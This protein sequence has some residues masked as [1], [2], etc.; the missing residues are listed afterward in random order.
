[1]FSDI[2]FQKCTVYM[3]NLRAAQKHV[4]EGL[5]GLIGQMGH[6]VG[7]CLPMV[8]KS[9]AL[10]SL[11]ASFPL[12]RPTGTATRYPPSSPLPL[13]AEFLV[14]RDD[15][16]LFID[17]LG[18]AATTSGLTLLLLQIEEL[19]ALN[20]T[21]F[22]DEE[23][24]QIPR[25]MEEI[26]RS[27]AVLGE[28][29]KPVATEASNTVF[30]VLKEIPPL[31]ASISEACRKARYFYLKGSLLPGMNLEINQDKNTVRSFLEKLGFTP[32][33][34]ESLNE[35]ERLYRAASTPFELKS[36]MGH[37]RSFLENLHLH[38]CAA[39]HKKVGGTLPTKWG[40]S[41][42]FLRNQSVLTVKEEQFVIQFYALTS[43]T[44]VHPLVAERE[45]A[46]LMRNMAIEYGLL[47]LTKLDKTGLI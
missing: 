44:G 12:E 22:T 26:K 40:E 2:A 43:D 37:L 46:R 5:F 3:C 39:L 36:C 19:I 34:I 31:C 23:Y 33:L 27:L 18:K 32:V 21:S 35:A 15:K 9:A 13:V 25:A 11:P 42:L 45:Y 38:G 17:A 4:L 24:L 14:R 41:V 47:L 30:H 1:M 20:F 29:R 28:K 6:H 16:Q 10:G 8:V 7:I